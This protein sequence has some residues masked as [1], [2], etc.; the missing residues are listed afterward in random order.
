MYELFYHL[1]KRPFF[2]T[3]DPDYFYR[4]KSCQKALNLL[5]LGLTNQLALNVLLGDVGIGKTSII[6][7]FVGQLPHNHIVG[8]VA[9][10]ETQSTEKLLREALITLGVV[11]YSNEKRDIREQ[12]R[13]FVNGKSGDSRK[14][15]L[16]IDDAEHLSFDALNALLAFIKHRSQG[17]KS[18][19][20]ILVGHWKLVEQYKNSYLQEFINSAG[21]SY[22]VQ[23]LNHQET[24]EYIQYRL[25]TAGAERTRMLDYLALDAVY[26]YSEGV[27]RIIN[28]LCD[29]AFG[30]GYAERKKRVDKFL[31]DK[32]A[33][34][35][36]RSLELDVSNCNQVER[37]KALDGQ[38]SG[39]DTGLKASPKYDGFD[40][41]SEEL[42][43]SGSS[44]SIVP[45]LPIVKKVVKQASVD[46][47]T[48]DSIDNHP[49]FSRLS[50]DEIYQSIN[51]PLMDS[52][53]KAVV[54]TCTFI[55]VSGVLFYLSTDDHDA[56]MVVMSNVPEDAH[57][58]Q[59]D[60][61]LLAANGYQTDYPI[62]PDKGSSSPLEA[63]SSTNEESHFSAIIPSTNSLIDDSELTVVK[64]L[65]VVSLE[66]STDNVLGISNGLDGGSEIK[67]APQIPASLRQVESEREKRRRRKDSLNLRIQNLIS[68]ADRQL[69]VQKLTSPPNDNAFATYTQLL[70][71][72]SDNEQALAGMRRVGE[73]YLA[74]AQS[75][76]TGRNYQKSLTFAD[77]GLKVIPDDARLLDL[78]N[79]IALKQRRAK[80][81]DSLLVRAEIQLGDLKL[82]W[83]KKDNAYETYQQVLSLEK[84]NQKADQGLERILQHYMDLTLK[85]EDRDDLTSALDYSEQALSVDPDHVRFNEKHQEIF[86]T[87]NAKKE[88]KTKINGL[89]VQARRQIQNR[90]VISPEGD[91]AVE[92][93]T[94]IL[95]VDPDNQQAS[96]GMEVLA[97]QYELLIRRK[98]SEDD[99]KQATIMVDQGIKK[100]LDPVRFKRLKKLLQQPPRKPVTS[101]TVKHAQSSAPEIE[102]PESHRRFR[103][104]G[105]F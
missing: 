27:P 37:Q 105:T 84:N 29:T 26:Q 2:L 52:Y 86:A 56:S 32:A 10:H 104:F 96:M 63:G 31:I 85:A 67:E 28:F 46:L 81:I 65:T 22:R 8:V 20:I 16:I 50:L 97:Q 98:I 66:G 100:F 38:F 78:K 9:M 93:Y 34:K 91:N 54:I 15:I 44:G 51:F 72:S 57:T 82:T 12:W 77:K 18:L 80:S 35:L 49:E 13:K 40:S 73:S 99:R 58:P 90:Q 36:K 1:E 83:P 60:T 70:K 74:L 47:E 71:I 76:L 103:S 30:Y 19:H 53:R 25:K 89:L 75:Q 11:D 7:H 33:F 41:Q 23:P 14:R 39:D 69:E 21:L 48:V 4:S 55:L 101:D 88:E 102:K 64:P 79:T 24:D 61:K 3:P 17:R 45:K 6:Q 43:A 5:E 94:N 95:N 42:K 59:V 68:L 62:V 92:S 87:I